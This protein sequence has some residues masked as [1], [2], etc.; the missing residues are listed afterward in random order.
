MNKLMVLDNK[1]KTRM[2]IIC[3]V[4]VICFLLCFVYYLTLILIC[5]SGHTAPGTIVNITSR[6]YDALFL[7][8]ATSATITAPIFIYCLAVLARLRHLNAAQKLEWVIFLLLVAPIASALFWIFLIKDA[9]QYA[10]IHP[11]IA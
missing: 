2:G 9:P 7:L 11:H 1:K 4:P 6:N 10:G 5:A 8:L 3:F